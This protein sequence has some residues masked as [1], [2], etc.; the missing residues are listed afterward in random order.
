MAKKVDD[1]DFGIDE[2]PIVS[3][4]VDLIETTLETK[5]DTLTNEELLEEL[6][7]RGIDQNTIHNIEA[8]KA[9]REFH[10]KL[11]SPKLVITDI[12]ELDQ[13]HLYSEKAVYN[14]L[15]TD[16]SNGARSEV[17]GIF[18]SAEKNSKE[19]LL[20]FKHYETTEYEWNQH[21]V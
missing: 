20:T 10:N 13:K 11:G 2:N 17:N 9:S 6:A 16:K 18:A 5:L 7:K 1:F 8:E 19:Y 21:G 4:E 14:C 3:T 15:N 12:K